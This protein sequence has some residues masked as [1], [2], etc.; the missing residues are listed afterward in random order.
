MRISAA[1]L[2]LVLLPS[3]TIGRAQDNFDQLL[4]QMNKVQRELEDRIFELE[5][6]VGDQQKTIQNLVQK[7]QKLEGALENSLRNFQNLQIDARILSDKTAESQK[8]TAELERKLNDQTE[9][10]HKMDLRLLTVETD[11]AQQKSE[12]RTA[13]FRL[14]NLTPP[15]HPAGVKTA[16]NAPKPHQ[17]VRPTVAQSAHLTHSR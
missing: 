15:P 2:G 9:G 3:P 16:A 13:A 1:F 5:I 12:L 8:K 10:V 6:K 17:A 7:D 14:D 11:V 4:R